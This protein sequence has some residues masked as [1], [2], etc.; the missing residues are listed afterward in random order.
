[1]QV[2]RGV[3]LMFHSQKSS[4]FFRIEK[5]EKLIPIPIQKFSEK[6]K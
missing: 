4:D 1:M 2:C 5:E 3:N 6:S